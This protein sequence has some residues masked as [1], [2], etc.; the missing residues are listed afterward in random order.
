MSK[1]S[2]ILTMTDIARLAGVSEATVSRALK[3]SPLINEKT[4]DR[5]QEIARA[6]NYRVNA[7]AR[8]FRL[9]T[10]NTLAVVLLVDREWGHELSDAFLMALLGSIADEAS[11]L[12]YD[13]LLSTNPQNVQDLGAFFVESKRADGLIVIGQGR[14]DPRL[15][16]L[17]HSS[18][19]FIVWG[20][21]LPGHDYVTVGS[22]N[23]QGGYAATRLLIRNGR[24]RIAFLGDVRHPEMEQRF[25]GYKDALAEAGLPFD[26]ALVI[27]TE[28]SRSYGYEK[29]DRIVLGHH[30]DCDAIFCVSDNIAL[31][32][33]KRLA[34]AGVRVPED[35]AVVGFDDIPIAAF[36]T[37][38]ITTVRQD[39]HEGGRMLVRNLL[40]LMNGEAVAH[41]VMP[42][43]LIVRQSCGQA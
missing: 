38:G 39:V 27:A 33:I 28:F 21:E 15:D 13:L 16:A 22:D 7:A 9:K 3:G 37:P 10:T 26:E 41:A 36:S 11:Q 23:R 1:G 12:G 20:A 19:P 40:K 43:Q 5:V 29:T 25:E 32:V 34:E 14:N 6:H 2:K 42:V 30:L 4:R 35:V 8:N 18:V 24:R 31:G 17:A